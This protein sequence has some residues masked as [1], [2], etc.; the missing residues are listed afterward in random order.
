V[1]GFHKSCEQSKSPRT[2]WRD[3]I[4]FT[5]WFS[6]AISGS[7]MRRTGLVI[8]AL[9]PG[10]YH[11]SLI[12]RHGVDVPYADEFTFVPLLVRPHQHALTFSELA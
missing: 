8:L 7:V 10:L 1:I 4:R 3:W 9:L 11:V 5:G 2:P 6:K 12:N